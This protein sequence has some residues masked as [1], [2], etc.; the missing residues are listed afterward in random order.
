MNE[1]SNGPGDDRGRFDSGTVIN[2]VGLLSGPAAAMAVEDGMAKP[3]AG[4]PVAFTHCELLNPDDSGEHRFSVKP[5]AS[6]DGD[7]SSLVSARHPFAG[8]DLSRP[9]IMGV[10]NVTPDSFSDGGDHSDAKDAIDHALK[11][12]EDGADILDIGGE[13][14]RPG[15]API[16]TAEECDRILPVVEAAVAAG[17]TVSV[18]TR[19]AETM[20]AAIAAGASIVNDVTALTGDPESLSAIAETDASVI[21]MHMQ[22]TPETMQ[23]APAYRLAS[24]DIFHWLKTRIEACEATGIS[25]DRIAVDPGIGFGKTDIH[26][27]EVLGRAAVFHG[28][29]CAVAIGVSRKSFIGRIAAVEVPKDRLPGTL[30][31]TGTALAR[32]IQIHRVHDVADVRQAFAIWR[33]EHDNG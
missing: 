2:P 6:V 30:A 12:V 23:N 16:G 20:R 10:V 3:L 13:S 25:R 14:T 28:L 11:L 24:F 9:V 1:V 31:A 19:R 26:N 33:A 22:G 15:A 17:V 32:G 8:H 5:N 4:G 7:L 21:L 27:M 29:G 18:D